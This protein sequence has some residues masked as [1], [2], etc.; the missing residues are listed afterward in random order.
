MT[1]LPKLQPSNRNREFLER[2]EVERA[3][4]VESWLMFGQ[5]SHRAMDDLLLGFDSRET[6]GWKSMGVLAYLGLKKEFKGFFAGVSYDKA[7]GILMEDN[8]NFEL[9]INY[10]RLSKGS[11]KSALDELSETVISEARRRD[12]SILRELDTTDGV[13]TS[14]NFY[15]REQ[16]F[17][18]ELMLAGKNN[19]K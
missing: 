6:R 2:S 11:Y 15:R 7:I 18:R 19:V 1:R 4:I 8:Q 9:V 12:A 3:K 17:L 16:T 14:Q 13:P 5:L 10:L